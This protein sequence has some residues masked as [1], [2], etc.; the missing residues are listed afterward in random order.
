MGFL[1]VRSGDDESADSSERGK[2]EAKP[3]L[4]KINRDLNRKTLRCAESMGD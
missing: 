2:D 3:E 1:S 4:T